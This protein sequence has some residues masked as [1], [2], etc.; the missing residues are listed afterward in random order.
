MGSPPWRT[1]TVDACPYRRTT[2]RRCEP[3]ST[4]PGHALAQGPD[5]TEVRGNVQPDLLESRNVLEV[6]RAAVQLFDVVAGHGKP[7]RDVLVGVSNVD[8]D[9]CVMGAVV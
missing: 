5:P 8:S 2:V 1:S 4:S 7:E 6:E 3:V 9:Q